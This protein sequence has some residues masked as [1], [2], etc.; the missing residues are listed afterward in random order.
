MIET[1]KI[2]EKITEMKG[3]YWQPKDLVG[4][5]NQIIRLAIFKG[6]YH[7]HKHKQEDELFLV[8][9]GSISIKLK[10]SKEIKVNAGEMVVIPKGIEHCPKS[11]EEAVVLLF[12]PKT[13][14][15][16]GD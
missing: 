4:V 13:I 6:E 5:N 14:T 12:E 15:S 3:I 9:R 1:I 11:E 2:E 7:W 16:K 8:Y 10:D